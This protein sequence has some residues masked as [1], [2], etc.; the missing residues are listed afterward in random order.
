MAHHV[1][2]IEHD[3]PCLEGKSAIRALQVPEDH[4][5]EYDAVRGAAG[6]HDNAHT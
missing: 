4:A 2:S 1:N 6:L 3:I 5:M